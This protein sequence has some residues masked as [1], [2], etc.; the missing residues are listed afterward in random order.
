[1]FKDKS[2]ILFDL[3]GTITDSKEGI[4]NSVLYSLEKM[5]K[6]GFKRDLLEGFLG[7][8]LTESFEKI[9][10]FSR[11]DAIRAVEIYREYFTDKGMFENRIYPGADLLIKN[12]YKAGRKSA[13]ATTK[14]EVYARRILDHFGLTE[15][16]TFIAGSRLDGSMTDKHLLIEHVIGNIGVS[17]RDE[18]VMC[19][20][21]Q[22]DI[23]GARSSKIMS[24]GVLYG[25]S[26]P[27]ELENAGA[28]QLVESVCEL[29]NTL[30]I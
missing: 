9:T 27:G 30:F 15:F 18:Y 24:I 25:Y 17:N 2:I 19:G 5:G 12:L 28:D 4:L 1:M 22:H 23:I 6:G 11:K 3:D 29:E 14:P 21:R 10:G 13:L 16:F 8:P 20:D 7:P 26:K